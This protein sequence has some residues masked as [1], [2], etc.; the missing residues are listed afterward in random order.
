V[1]LVF[2]TNDCIEFMQIKLNYH[3]RFYQNVVFSDGISVADLLAIDKNLFIFKL[4]REL[5][6]SYL[7]NR[8][9]RRLYEK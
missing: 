7:E 2:D 5:F 4:V 3:N 6:F 1:V 9:A 8:I